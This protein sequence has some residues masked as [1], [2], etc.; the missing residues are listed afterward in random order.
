MVKAQLISPSDISKS[1]LDLINASIFLFENIYFYFVSF[2][3]IFCF[4]CMFVYIQAGNAWG[5]LKTL[6][7]ALELEVQVGSFGDGAVNVLNCWAVSPA[8]KILLG[9]TLF[10]FEDIET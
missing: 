3:W 8:L 5:N 7:D 4:A 10:Y 9:Q 1:I 2:E 6:S